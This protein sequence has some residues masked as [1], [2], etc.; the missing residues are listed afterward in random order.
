MLPAES[1]NCTQSSAGCNTAGR[2]YIKTKKWS[3]HKTFFLPSATFLLTKACP[4]IPLSALSN[5][6]RRYL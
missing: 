3:Q 5:L 2:T 6:V 4:T 1:A